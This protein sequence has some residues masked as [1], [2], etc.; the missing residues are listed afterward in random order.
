MY[1]VECGWVFLVGFVCDGCIYGLLYI[2]LWMG[3]YWNWIGWLVFGRSW[4][5][6]RLFCLLGSRMVWFCCWLVCIWCLFGCWIVVCV[7]GCSWVIVVFILCLWSYW[8][9][10]FGIV[11]IC[12]YWFWFCIGL[13]WNW[14]LCGCGCWEVVGLVCY[15]DWCWVVLWLLLLVVYWGCFWWL[16]VVCY[17]YLRLM[18]CWY[19]FVYFCWRLLY[20]FEI[21]WFSLI[22]L[23]SGELSVG[24]FV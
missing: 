18:W 12:W 21:G 16:S 6:S 22:L 23:C 14:V 7:G 3:C 13:G 8:W 15:W 2:F 5:W 4:C 24:I 10:L 1:F 11:W 17:C 9:L 19:W 20:V